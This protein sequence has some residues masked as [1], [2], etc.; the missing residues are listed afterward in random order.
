MQAHLRRLLPASL[1]VGLAVVLAVS[2]SG[3]HEESVD[4]LR[5]SDGPTRQ[6]LARRDLSARQLIASDPGTLDLKSWARSLSDERLRKLTLEMIE[7][8]VDEPTEGIPWLTALAM[9][10]GRRDIEGMLEGCSH[11]FEGGSFMGDIQSFTQFELLQ[12]LHC[13]AAA[14]LAEDDPERA[15]RIFEKQFGTGTRT[16]SDF[17]L[18][19][20]RNMGQATE[21]IFHCWAAKD[22]VAAWSEISS[23]DPLQKPTKLPSA[24]HGL[25]AGTSDPELRQEIL[26]WV[27]QQ[28]SDLA[29]TVIP[30]TEPVVIPGIP[31]TPS[32]EVTHLSTSIDLGGGGKIS[33]NSIDSILNNPNRSFAIHGPSLSHSTAMGLAEHD[34]GEAID[35]LMKSIGP[36]LV[37]GSV[38]ALSDDPSMQ[39][40]FQRQGVSRFLSEWA[41]EN[42]ADATRYLAKHP[43]ALEDWHRERLA[44]GLVRREPE[45][46]IVAL[47]GI[48]DNAQRLASFLHLLK[49]PLRQG[50]SSDPWPISG[51]P[52]PDVSHAFALGILK[53]GLDQL[54]FSAEDRQLA[55]DNINLS[56]VRHQLLQEVDEAWDQAKPPIDSPAAE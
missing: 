26:D 12:S 2:R 31:V 19:P 42:P 35:W 48:D 13:A 39:E 20:N 27:G 1:L 40:H 44:D 6:R 47:S 16:N 43:D 22:P 25:L 3:E 5:S 4:A 29:T 46:A 18:L 41:D 11:P 7:Q 50:R 55:V 51:T 33:R 30:V 17:I 54:G 24:I 38:P 49:G 8:V 34:P 36:P 28:E 21:Q 10:W 32:N 23:G 45:A 37:D 56:K 15:W 52:P 14:G 9:E 53:Q